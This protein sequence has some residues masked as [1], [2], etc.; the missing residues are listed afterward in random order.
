MDET[1]DKILMQLMGILND[2][3][4]GKLEILEISLSKR[5]R[6]ISYNG[7]TLTNEYTGISDLTITLK[8]NSND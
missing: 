1:T 2:I 5:T 6:D 4:N 8:E 7:F 3:R